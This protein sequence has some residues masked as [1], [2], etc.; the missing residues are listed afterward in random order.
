MAFSGIV[1][2]AVILD[3]FDKHLRACRFVNLIVVLISFNVANT[4]THTHTHTH[5]HTQHT[6]PHPAHAHNTHNT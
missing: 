2:N 3:E 5:T 1:D 6:H 4:L